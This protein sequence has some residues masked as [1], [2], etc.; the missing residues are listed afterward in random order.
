MSGSRSEH[1]QLHRRVVA[2]RS[3]SGGGACTL[4]VWREGGSVLVCHEGAA[5]STAQFTAAQ[6]MELA[7]VLISA[8]SAP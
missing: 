2:G 1:G 4:I 5:V 8:A 7:Q 6:A 3:W